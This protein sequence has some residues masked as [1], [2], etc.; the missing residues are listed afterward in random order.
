MFSCD[1]MSIF[2]QD[3][4]F[5]RYFGIK[6]IVF[7]DD[8]YDDLVIEAI[9]QNRPE[10][11]IGIM[12]KNKNYSYKNGTL[13]GIIQ[14]VNNK[15][16]NSI[17][18]KQYTSPISTLLIIILC[19][20]CNFTLLG[21]SANQTLRSGFVRCTLLHNSECQ[22]LIKKNPQLKQFVNDKFNI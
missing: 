12:Q 4:L 8:N 11:A 17:F 1:K 7:C 10:K 14:I 15:T 19:R 20:N 3:N 22:R 2:E 18:M 21:W 13:F 6:S 16:I 9:S 5:E